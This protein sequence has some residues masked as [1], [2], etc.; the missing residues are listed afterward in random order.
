MTSRDDQRAATYRRTVDVAV[1]RRPDH[2]GGAVPCRCEPGRLHLAVQAS[3]TE[4][5]V[6]RGQVLGTLPAGLDV[7]SVIERA[8][9]KSA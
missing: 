1:L 2:G 4:R 6:P 3:R 8:Q 9:L 5:P 7:G